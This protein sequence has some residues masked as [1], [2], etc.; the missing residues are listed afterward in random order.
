MALDSQ[1]TAPVA[2]VTGAAS[3]IGY[4]TAQLLSR[5]GFRTFGTSR[6]PTPEQDDAV[7]MLT[8]EVSDDASARHCLNAVLDRTGRLDVLVNNVGGGIAGAVEE[9]SITEAQAV[10]EVNLWGAVRVTQAALPVMR[11]QRSG[12]VIVMSFAPMLV[13]IPF[14]G[15][16]CAS[17]FALESMFDA[18]RFEVAASGVHVS[19]IKPGAV[20]THA[21][22]RVPR[23]AVRLDAYADTRERLTQFFDGAMRD[24]MPPERA[25]RAV[26][27]AAT[28][29]RPRPRYLVGP[30]GR[31]IY[32]FQ[33]AT[34]DRVVRFLLARLL[35][36]DTKRPLT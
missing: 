7:E 33:R 8:L 17:K 20:A 35:T 30:A 27:K 5:H 13:G 19:I 23:A 29:R 4:A 21:A 2:L 12:R 18:L 10:F 36:L 31:S 16:Y 25:A 14:R 28:A 24:G 22:D 9:T 1:S 11:A 34:P 26:L 15:A 3:G 6:S 32:A